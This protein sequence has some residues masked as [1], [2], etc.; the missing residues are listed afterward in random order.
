MIRAG[1]VTVVLYGP[2]R[3]GDAPADLE[4]RLLE[5]RRQLNHRAAGTPAREVVE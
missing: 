2:H 4:V 3:D 5:Q 1:D